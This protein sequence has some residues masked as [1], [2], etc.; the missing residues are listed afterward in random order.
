[1][2]SATALKREFTFRLVKRKFG[3]SLSS[4]TDTAMK[5]QTLA[6]FVCHNVCC[7]IQEM[8]ESGFDPTAWAEP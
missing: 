2:R 3:N 7:T 4:K 5:N 1:L 6:K 8:H